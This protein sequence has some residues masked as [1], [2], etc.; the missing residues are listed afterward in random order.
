M[1]KQILI[2]VLAAVFVLGSVAWYTN[3]PDVKTNNVISGMMNDQS[4]T[5][6]LTKL[7]E[8]DISTIKPTEVVEL[9]DGDVF[10]LEATIVKQEVGNRTIKRLAYNGQ[11]PGPVI[12]VQKGAGATVN[13]TNNI[14]METSLHAHGLR[15]DWQMDGAVPIT[16]SVQ[17]G[18]TFSYKLEFPDTGVFWYHPHVREDYQQ[19]LGLYGNFIVEEVD[20]WNPVDQ[21]AYLIVDDMLEDGEF[22]RDEVTNVLMGRFGDRLL[23]N[24]QENYEL[25]VTQGEITRAFIT[26]VANTRTFDLTFTG[27]EMKLVGGDV[28]RIEQE[29]MIE[30]QI[31]GTSERYVIELYYGEPG[32]YAIEHRGKNMGIVTVLP[33]ETNR[34]SEFVNLR[35]NASDYADIRSQVSVLA[36]KTPDKN[37]RLDI[38]MDGMGGMRG[39]DGMND[40]MGNTDSENVNLMGMEMTRQQAVEHCEMMPGMAGCEPFLNSGEETDSEKD[41]GKDGIEWEDDMAMMNNMSTSEMMEWF[42]E[43]TDTG[44][45]SEDINWSFETGELVKIRIYNDEKGDHPMQHPIHFHGQKFVI[46]ATDGVVNENLQWKD[47]ALIPTGR[48]VDLLIDMSNPGNWMAHCHIAEHLEAGMMFQFTVE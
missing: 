47:S 27:A 8:G 15:G 40:M 11:I 2:S 19:E 6:A 46:L 9:K 36:A 41:H 43:D 12:K 17:V 20:Y 33:S 44:A 38:K 14:D 32:T 18:E 26:N 48:T 7:P 13:F 37:L 21:E 39:M 5:F 34:Y 1:N 28:G 10:D 3:T 45:R 31:I 22:S 35:S 4:E 29:T 23:I 30:S 42:I 25:T 16:P 24:D